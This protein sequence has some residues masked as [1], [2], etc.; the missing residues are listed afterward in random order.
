MTPEKYR[1]LEEERIAEARRRG[2]C[3]PY[4]K[5]YIRPDGSPVPVLIGFAALEEGRDRFICFVLDLTPQK[6]VEAALKEAD[7]RKD[8]FLA[9]LAHELRNPLA[10][11]LNAV[12]VMQLLGPVDPNLQ[13]AREMIERQVGHLARLVDDLLDVSRITRGKIKLQ[14]AAV[15]LAAV[16][17]RAVETSQPLMEARR[18]ELTVTLPPGPTWVEG[19][20]ARLAQVVSNLLNNAAKYT[21]DGGHIRL[22]AERGPGEAV[23]RVEDDGM[24]IHADL[25][26]HVFELFTQGDRSPARSEGGLGIG[27]TLVKSLV[28]MHGGGVEARSEGAGKGSEFVVRL[29]VLEGKLAHHRGRRGRTGRRAADPLPPRPGRGR[30]RG[31]GRN[32]GRV[33]AGRGARGPHRPRRPRRPASGRVV[34]ARGRLSGHRTTPDG[35]L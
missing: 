27:L 17:A 16:I 4:E 18:H 19:D 12:Q 34:P 29:P 28:E 32:A 5:E 3:T 20:A 1:P 25:L 24:G 31:R 21:E 26:P 9:M 15:E 22:T 7:R 2:A 11:V 33:S 30:Q 14:K 8:E 35:R 6:R 23:V 10:P 13:R